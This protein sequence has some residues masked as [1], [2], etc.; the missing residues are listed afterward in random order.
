MPR[1]TASKTIAPATV[2]SLPASYEAGTR[3]ISDVFADFFP[4]VPEQMR[5]H[6]AKESRNDGAYIPPIDWGFTW[7]KDQVKLG[8]QIAAGSISRFWLIDG[9]PGCGKTEFAYQLAARTN[10]GLTVVECHEGIEAD[11]LFS[12]MEPKEGSKSGFGRTEGPIVR[13]MKNGDL[14]VLDE[15]KG[16]RN[17]VQLALYN[18]L[19][20]RPIQLRHNGEIVVPHE[21]FRVIATVNDVGDEKRASF[22]GSFS[23][24]DPLKSRFVGAR[25]APLPTHEEVAALHKRV[26]SICDVIARAL[27]NIAQA[28]RSEAVSG[29]MREFSFRELLHAGRHL[30]ANTAPADA[31]GAEKLQ[32][33]GLVA[34]I[35]AAYGNKEALSCGTRLQQLVLDQRR[36]LN[37]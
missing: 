32:S 18:L 2:G 26:P 23:L 35:A 9:P 24:T 13:A 31:T 21:E 33:D 11:S 36:L 27:V 37:L 29:T 15:L 10:R 4:E 8:Q 1:A 16:L 19:D 17:S 34:A 25:F 20:G 7:S 6:C 30:V 22:K 5:I 3:P 28:V 14:L 12:F